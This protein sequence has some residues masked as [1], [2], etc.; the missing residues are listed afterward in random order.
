MCSIMQ[1]LTID[2]INTCLNFTLGHKI[3]RLSIRPYSHLGDLLHNVAKNTITIAS[4][5]LENH[6]MIAVAQV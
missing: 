2:N 6:L 4:K 3:Y 1:K 5:S